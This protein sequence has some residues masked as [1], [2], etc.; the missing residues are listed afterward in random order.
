MQA[1]RQ[2]RVAYDLKKRLTEILATFSHDL[3]L[4]ALCRVTITEVKVSGDLRSAAVKIALG[5]SLDNQ[6][7]PKPEDVLKEIQ[8]HTPHI[9]KKLAPLITFKSVP[10]L[11]FHLD[12]Q[13]SLVKL[14]EF[15]KTLPDT[16]MFKEDTNS[17]H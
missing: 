12:S 6:T 1:T 11:K 7:S 2:V 5:F 15:F 4:S 9:Q 13:E 16:L 3:P 8:A 10:S 17:E 14:Q